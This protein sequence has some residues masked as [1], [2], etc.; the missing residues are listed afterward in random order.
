MKLTKL[1]KIILLIYI[2]FSSSLLSNEIWL[3]DKNLSTIEFELPVLFSNNVK[4]SFKD[5]EGLIEI[6]LNKKINNKAIFSITINS[7]ELNYKKYRK[8]IL[9]DI[10]FQS[11][12]YPLALVDTKKFSYK[13]EKKINL[14]VDLTIKNITETV[15]LKLEINHLAEEL[16]QI[17]SKLIFSRTAFKI[18]INNWASTI[19]LGDKV[20]IK[21]NFFLFKK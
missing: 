6:D 5:I 3:L 11:S 21:T 7:I 18:G 20:I 19:I 8:L 15:P 12:K 1:F 4:G 17:K 16:V 14:N 13:D 9:G 2:F 10:F